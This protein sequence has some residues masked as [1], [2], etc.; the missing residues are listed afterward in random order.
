[1]QL[2]PEGISIFGGAYMVENNQLANIRN[3]IA[4]NLEEFAAVYNDKTFK[5]K[6]DTIQGEQN[7]R[8]PKELQELAEK[9]PLILNKQFFY[10]TNL[11]P[12][13]ITSESLVETLMEYY[14]AGKKVNAFLKRAMEPVEAN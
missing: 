1:M 3:Y 11:K 4:E 2:S 5:A 7:K 6:F 14:L 13:L 12:E 9:E 10:S 8:V